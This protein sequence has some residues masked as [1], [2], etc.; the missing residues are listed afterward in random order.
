MR[1]VFAL[2]LCA[3]LVGAQGNKK[4]TAANILADYAAAL[5]NVQQVKALHATGS[6]GGDLGMSV[7]YKDGKCV[8]TTTGLAPISL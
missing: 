7:Y 6:L 8:R 5:G 4:R 2:V 1:V 3:S